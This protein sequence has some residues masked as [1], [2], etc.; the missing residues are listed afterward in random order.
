MNSKYFNLFSCCEVVKGYSRS[1]I[2]DNQRNVLNTIPNSLLEVISLTETLSFQEIL[3]R[4]YADKKEIEN[5][6]SWLINQEF[7]FWC[8][9][10]EK[11]SFP[12][13][14]NDYY[15]PHKLENII[16]DYDTFDESNFLLSLEQIIS[17]KIPCVQIRIYKQIVIE[18]LIYIVESLKDTTIETVEVIADLR[19]PVDRST[20]ISLLKKELRIKSIILYNSAEDE[21]IPVFDGLSN[22]LFIQ[23][24]ITSLSCGVIS[25]ENFDINQKTFFQSR[26]HNSCLH[27]KI[28]IDKDGNIKNCPSMAQSYGNIKVTTLERALSHSDFTKY[29]NVTKENITICKDCEFRHICTDCRAYTERTDFDGEMDLSKPLKCGYN[30]YTN[31]WSEWSTNPLKERAI[32]FYKMNE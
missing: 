27:K 24:K 5:Y 19:N 29:W 32:E 1:V 8:E 10:S 9:K 22:I 2:I 31:E 25:K 6:F 28:S 17:I 30:P 23:Q 16:L 14:A 15:S 20:L 12:K 4:F 18:D 21:V 3:E 13:V 11:K 26:N 7:G